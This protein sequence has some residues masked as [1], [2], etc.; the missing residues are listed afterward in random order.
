MKMVLQTITAL[1]IVSS[2]VGAS[3]SIIRT[4]QNEVNILNIYSS[5]KE[6][7]EAI[8]NLDTKVDNLKE[9]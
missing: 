7:K 9:F 4:Y 5:L 8:K 2:I 3:A 6:I 1:L